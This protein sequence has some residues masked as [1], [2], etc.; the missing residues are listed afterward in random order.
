MEE[1]ATF[2]FRRDFQCL[3]LFARPH[4]SPACAPRDG[5]RFLGPSP[6]P[7][8]PRRAQ[9]SCLAPNLRLGPQ[10]LCTPVHSTSGMHSLVDCTVAAA[11]RDAPIGGRT[12]QYV[13]KCLKWGNVSRGRGAPAFSPTVARR[14][15][16][17]CPGG[18]RD[19]WLSAQPGPA[20]ARAN[21][22]AGLKGRSRAC[23]TRNGRQRRA[24]ALDTADGQSTVRHETPT[25]S[26]YFYLNFHPH[27]E[28]ARGVGAQASAGLILPT[29][30]RG[31]VGV[32]SACASPRRAPDAY[33]PRSR[34]SR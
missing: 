12:L 28:L 21:T 11:R 3:S 10:L 8:R 30:A 31:V 25:S 9:P 19:D 22:G 6:P 20:P 32:R 4:P 7:G 33:R 5:C 27:C 15:A 17:Y 16:A 18:G 1:A 24:T 13:G 26:Y 29:A 2:E 34:A 23:R 14:G